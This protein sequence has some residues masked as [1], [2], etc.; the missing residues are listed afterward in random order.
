MEVLKITPRGYC[1][2]V[3]DAFRIAKRVREETDGPVHML[4]MLVHNTHATDDL[5]RQ[6]VALV[7][8]PNR[9][10]GLEQIKE[11]TVIFTAHGVSPAVKERAMELGLKPVDATCSDV[12]RTH[13]L[14]ADLANKGYEVVYIGRK[15]HPEPEGVMGEAPGKVYL[16]QDPEDIDALDLKGERI[17]VTCQTTLSIWDTEDLIGRVRAR[18]PQAEVYNEICRATQERQEAAVE[19]AREVDLVIVVGSPRSSNSLRLVEVVKELGKKPAYLVD[20]L[21]DLDLAW[22]KGKK[23]VG[24]TSGASTPTQLTRRVIE[25]LEALEAPG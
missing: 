19:A 25:Y 14:V 4:G 3:V 13:E 23:R 18:Y 7:D 6:G 20:R 5:Q 12:V 17:A 10:A 15:G 1:H 2:G 16:V 24:V 21:E 22:F 8:Q 11:G 9:L